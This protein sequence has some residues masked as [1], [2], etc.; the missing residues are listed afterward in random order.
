LFSIKL[1]GHTVGFSKTGVVSLQ[2]L[3]GLTKSTIQQLFS[4]SP[5]TR[6]L[7]TSI[8]ASEENIQLSGLMGSAISFTVADLFRKSDRPFLLIF[9]DKEEAAYHLN[10]LEQ[11]VGEHDVLFY[12]GSYR[13]P[14]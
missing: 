2:K 1:I 9:S 7:Q 4:Q 13:R 6:K 12:P 5:Q 11:L 3:Y 8:A 14:Y 10:D